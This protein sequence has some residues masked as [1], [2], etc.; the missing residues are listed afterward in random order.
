LFTAGLWDIKRKA[1]GGTENVPELIRVEPQ[2]NGRPS[3][4]GTS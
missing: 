1:K 2:P 3:I 4:P